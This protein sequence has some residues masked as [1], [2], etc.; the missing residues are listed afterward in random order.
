MCRSKERVVTG[1]QALKALTL[2]ELAEILVKL[3][4]PNSSLYLSE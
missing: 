1:Q 4:E 2:F 3:G